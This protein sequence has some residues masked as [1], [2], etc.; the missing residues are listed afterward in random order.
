VVSGEVGDIKREIAYLGDALNVTA[1]L[2]EAAKALDADAVV[3]M[4][5]LGRLGPLPA[6]LAAT[7]LPPIVVKGKLEPVAIARLAFA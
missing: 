4:A 5:L 3:S 7:P 1:R 2:E 6:G